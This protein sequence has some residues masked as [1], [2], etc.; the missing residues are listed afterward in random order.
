[1]RKQRHIVAALLVLLTGALTLFGGMYFHWYRA[2]YSGF[3]KAVAWKIDMPEAA[4]NFAMVTPAKLYRSGEPDAEFLDYVRRRYGIK[5]VVSLNG[6]SQVQRIARNLG[7]EVKV[8]DWRTELPTEELRAVLDFL[9][10]KTGVLVH[11]RAGRDSTGTVIAAYRMQQQHWS[12]SRALQ[13][14]E[15]YGHSRSH[16]SETDQF[17]RHWIDSSR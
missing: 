2:P 14:M 6:V 10:E 17:L 8:F 3:G 15:A 1:M 16:R 13:E 9:N 12:V 7:M 11:C 5:Y 4:Y